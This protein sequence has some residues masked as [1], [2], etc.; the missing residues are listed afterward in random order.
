MKIKDK[1]VLKNGAVGGYVYYPKDKKWK[2]RIIS[3]PKKKGGSNPSAKNN[4]NNKNCERVLVTPLS[5]IESEIKRNLNRNRSITTK[6]R[7]ET[8]KQWK[9]R[10]EGLGFEVVNGKVSLP[11]VE[12]VMRNYRKRRNN[13]ERKLARNWGRNNNN[14]NNNNNGANREYYNLDKKVKNKRHYN[15]LEKVARAML[16]NNPTREEYINSLKN[17]ISL[18]NGNDEYINVLSRVQ[19]KHSGLPFRRHYQG[20]QG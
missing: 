20:L 16:P 12:N 14:L 19:N 18:Y 17:Q 4:K 7:G 1:R 6:N 15:V 8:N 13:C 3:G 11:S 10:V 9:E 5:T 2:W